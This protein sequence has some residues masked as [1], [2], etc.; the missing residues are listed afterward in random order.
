MISVETVKEVLAKAD[1]N[2]RFA[3]IRPVGSGR[4]WEVFRAEAECKRLAFGS[5]FASS[6]CIRIRRGQSHIA[7]TCPLT[8]RLGGVYSPANLFCY[9]SSEYSVHVYPWIGGKPIEGTDMP[10][11]SDLASV[12]RLVHSD[13]TQAARPFT[14]DEW[15]DQMHARLR[16]YIPYL[17]TKEVVSVNDPTMRI[18][19]SILGQALSD[20][21][22]VRRSLIHRDL[23]NSNILLTPDD[24]SRIAAIIDWDTA[25]FGDYMWDLS[26]WATFHDATPE[27]FG[28]MLRLYHG[29]E[30][31]AAIHPRLWRRFWIYFLI[32]SLGKFTF[33]HK[34]GTPD[35]T[36]SFNRVKMGVEHLAS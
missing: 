29:Y 5:P 33:H 23:S 22:P 12:L 31:V 28:E 17:I 1:A 14:G 20:L 34:L 13:G 9:E 2:Y 15:V 7:L 21:E 25:T 6:V 11:L 4:S 16:P 24:P 8:F 10:W 35:L 30:E 32:I 19:N 18:A 36:R 3:D 26:D 27:C